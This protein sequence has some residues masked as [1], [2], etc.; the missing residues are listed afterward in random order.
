MEKYIFGEVSD[1]DPLSFKKFVKEIEE[2]INSDSEIVSRSKECNRKFLE[3]L[4][5]LTESTKSEYVGSAVLGLIYKTPRYS[6]IKNLEFNG[7]KYEAEIDGLGRTFR[8]LEVE[9]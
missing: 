5:A 9:E 2:T 3:E 7:K 8:L 4:S 1:S 6:Y